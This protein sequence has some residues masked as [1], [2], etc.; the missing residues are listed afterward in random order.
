[1]KMQASELEVTSKKYWPVLFCLIG[2]ID[3]NLY[4]MINLRS[5][6]VSK[7]LSQLTKQHPKFYNSRLI[8]LS[9]GLFGVKM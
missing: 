5:I 3:D 7:N 4:G 6:K 1:M 8:A 2:N 9:S